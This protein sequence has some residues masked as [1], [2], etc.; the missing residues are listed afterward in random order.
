[1]TDLGP[2]TVEDYIR[3]L[4]VGPRVLLDL[5]RRKDRTRLRTPGRVADACRVVSYHEYSGVSQ[6]LEGTELP[7]YNSEAEVYVRSRGVYTQFYPQS[8]ATSEAAVELLLWDHIY[9]VP[10]DRL[11]LWKSLHQQIATFS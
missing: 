1:V 3:L 11:M 5:P 10:V 7:Q 4:E 9:G 2:T 6:V 8:L